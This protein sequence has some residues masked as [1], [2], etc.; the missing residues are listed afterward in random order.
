M[1]NQDVLKL[2]EIV[3]QFTAETLHVKAVTTQGS[4]LTDDELKKTFS[5]CFDMIYDKLNTLP[6]V[7]TEELKD[8]EE[9]FS[10]ISE[11]HKIFAEKFNDYDRR[12]NSLA[13]RS[14]RRPV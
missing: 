5:T 3:T 14:S 4:P 13:P 9:K 2:L 1:T 12:L 11:M 6:H 7:E 8:L 10:T